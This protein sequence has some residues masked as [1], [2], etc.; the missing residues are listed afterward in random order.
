M[1]RRQLLT[2]APVLALLPASVGALPAIA[3]SDPL[4]ALVDQWMEARDAW[5]VEVEKPGGG[6]FDT[7]ECLRMESIQR[8]FEKQIA[9]TPVTGADGAGALLRMAW[10]EGDAENDPWPSM[11]RSR[12]AALKVWAEGVA[13]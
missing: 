5:I 1:N 8:G 9:D 7:P 2:T 12:L 10:I 4:V 11:P 13:S 6:N 3:S